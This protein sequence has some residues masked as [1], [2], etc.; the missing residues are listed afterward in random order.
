[1]KQVFKTLW[2]SPLMAVLGNLLLMMLLFTFCRVFFF[3]IYRDTF[4]DM[5]LAHFAEICGGGLRFDL[6]ALLLFNSPYILLALLPLRQR[7]KPVYQ[8]ALKTL[9]LTINILLLVV[10]CADMAYFPFTNRRTTITVFDEFSNDGNLLKIITI[11]LFDYWYITLFCLGLIAILVVGYRRCAA[12]DALPKVT[13]YVV[14]T[15]VLLVCA[16]FTVIGIRG[17]FGAYTRPINISNAAQYIKRPVENALVL[18]TP[19]SLFTTVERQVY[20]S[21]AYFSETELPTIFSPIHRPQPQGDFRPMNVVVIIMESFGKEYIGFY[22]RHL[23]GGNYSGYTPFLDSL[24]TVSYT[25]EHSFANGRKS[26]DAMPSVLSSIPMFI[27]PYITTPYATNAVSSIADVLKSHG[28][29]SAFFHG[30]PNGSMGFQA[31]ANAAGYDDYFGM[32]EYGNEQD[33][34]GVWAIWDEEFFQFFADRMGSF[35]QPFVTTIFSASSHHPFAVPQRYEGKFPEGTLPIHKCIGYSDY[36]L[37]RFFDRVKQY[38]WYENTLFVFTADHTNVSNCAE[39]QTDAGV[40]AV[41]I[42]FYC[43]GDSTL[44]GVSQTPVAQ[45]DVLPTVLSYLRNDKPYFAFGSDA[46]AGDG[47]HYVCNYNNGVYQLFSD[48]LLVQFDGKTTVAVYNYINDRLLQHNLNG[49]IDVN[50]EERYLQAVIQQ[51]IERMVSDS[52]TVH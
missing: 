50:K 5:T 23:D 40:F 42:A 34:D 39:Y 14:H 41:P 27:E 10:N 18:N 9:F 36:A 16:Y 22:N 21:P 15:A 30:A 8:T 1:M 2:H 7:A 26:I 28:Y 46:F 32:T 45:T 31:Y 24:L 47:L 17:G 35:R 44:R 13:Y 25:F 12:V 52:L 4:A 29:Y 19:F 11:G 20:H 48:S 37:R 51:Y 49:T 43:A 6:S 38:P 3:L 33:F